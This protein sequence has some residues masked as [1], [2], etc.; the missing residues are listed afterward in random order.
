MEPSVIAALITASVS[1]G[2]AWLVARQSA[3]SHTQEALT[4]AWARIDALS[5]RVDTLEA[6]RRE[7]A[8]LIRRMGDH[9]DTLEHH[10]WQQLPPPPP[11]RPDGI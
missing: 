5:A 2:G 3:Q 11:P 7:D 10:I 6:A 4:D 9:I 8:A 1:M